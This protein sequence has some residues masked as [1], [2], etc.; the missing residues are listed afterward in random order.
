MIQRG[1][2]DQ[3]SG[4]GNELIL[5]HHQRLRQIS[6]HP[7]I[8][9]L[10]DMTV[11]FGQWYLIW[12]FIEGVSLADSPT[13]QTPL[14]EFQVRHILHSLLPVLQAVHR[15][16]LIHRDIKPDNII[17][18]AQQKLWLV[19]FGAAVP[20]DSSSIGRAS[21]AVNAEYGAPEQLLGQPTFASDLY[22]L[23]LICL[24][25]LTLV[26]PFDLYAVVDRQGWQADLPNPIT[27]GLGQILTKL[28][29][30]TQ[31][32]YRTAA[33]VLADLR[34]LPAI[35]AP[36][37]QPQPSGASGRQLKQRSASESWL[38]RH[39]LTEHRGAI[40]AIAVNEAYVVSG[41]SDGTIQIWTWQGQ[42]LYQLQTPWFGSGH[43]D[44]ISALHIDGDGLTLSSSSADGTLCRWSLVDYSRQ[45]LWVSP[46]WGIGTFA[47]I[48]GLLVSG[49]ANGRIQLW[50]TQNGVV[51][52]TWRQHQGAISG[53]AI[54]PNQQ[55]L[56]SGSYDGTVRLWDLKTAAVNN[57]LQIGAPVTAIAV[58][59]HWDIL[60]IGDK[61]GELQLWD[62]VTMTRLRTMTAHEGPIATLSQSQHCLA[63]GGEDAQI[64][65]WAMPNQGREPLE[66]SLLKRP[67]NLEQQAT[68]SHDW[69]VNAI[70]FGPDGDWLASG[71]ADETLQLWQH[72]P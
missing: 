6:H 68:L 60:A 55:V 28:L 23:G 59:A 35:A 24:Q 72:Q 50:D 4:D 16:G 69:S 46:G 47:A 48:P 70:A 1:H 39:T 26:A 29:R 2:V 25:R 38:C 15:Q 52:E 22:S 66:Q 37:S 63:S 62:I 31:Q 9:Q 18:G 65:L 19:D 34:A 56:L 10:L 30:P 45:A 43:R 8:P 49:G 13:Q 40:T 51:I 33:S 12:E 27:P 61:R 71:S 21:S 54:S 20:A 14:M 67:Q 41:S 64:H 36:L 58:M 7:Q 57:V 3:S 44:R 11:Q 53:L 17:C 5:R 32:R 42:R